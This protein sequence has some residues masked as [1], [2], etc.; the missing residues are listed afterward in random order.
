MKNTTNYKFLSSDWILTC[1]DNFTI[2]QNGAIVFDKQIIDIGPQEDLLK[3]YPHLQNQYCGVNSVL[4]PGLI[5]SHIHLEFSAN[6][7]TLKYGNFMDWLGSVIANRED[8]IEKATKKLIDKELN[9]ML[10]SGTTTIGAISSYGF[11]MP[12]CIDSPLNV[13]YFTEVIGSKADMVDTLFTDFQARLKSAKLSKKDN[14]IPAIAIHSPY[15][16]H[17]FL[18]REVLKIA[19][20]ENLSVSAHFQESIAENEWLNKSSGEFTAFF[21]NFLQQTISTGKPSEFLQLFKGVKNL[22]FTHCVQANKDELVQIKELEAS[23]IHCPKSNRLLDNSLLNL[24]YIKDINL[25][26]GTDG[27]SSNNSLSL[28]DEIKTAFFMHTSIHP[29]ILSE[30]LLLNATKGGADCLGLNKG[31]LTKDKDAD[32]ISFTLPDSCDEKQNLPT[33]IILHTSKVDQTYIQ[34]KYIELS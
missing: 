14:F 12:S 29:N 11:D 33:A 5:N 22:S 24:N 28:F 26:I 3:K 21:K 9:Q 25:A 4:M 18:V 27:L 13:V 30:Q 6:K 15:S 34:G 20:D 1:D 2:I 19:K 8:L 23:I 10:Q 16:V 32:I 31:I 7:T 17:P